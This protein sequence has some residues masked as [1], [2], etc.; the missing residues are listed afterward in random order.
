MQKSL[1][2][3]EEQGYCCVSSLKSWLHRLRCLEEEHCLSKKY[4]CLFHARS[5]VNGV[6]HLSRFGWQMGQDRLL[7]LLVAYRLHWDSLTLPLLKQ[8][9]QMTLYLKQMEHFTLLQKNSPKK[10]LFTTQFLSVTSLATTVDV[11][12]Q[13]MEQF[14]W[15][16]PTNRFGIW[17]A[18]AVSGR[19]G[20]GVQSWRAQPAQHWRF[21]GLNLTLAFL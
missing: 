2:K 4:L 7:V 3:E 16:R 6:S 12:K 5:V 10:W 11:T 1:K 20:N 17:P 9:S 13:T 19:G 15:Q 8:H 14:C 21:R 18:A